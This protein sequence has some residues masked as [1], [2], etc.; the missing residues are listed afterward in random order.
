[1]AKKVTPAHKQ[2]PGQ[3]PAPCY[4][5]LMLTAGRSILTNRLPYNL[6]LGGRYLQNNVEH[7]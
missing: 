7:N 6:I 3:S 1:M 4:R 5:G 2:V